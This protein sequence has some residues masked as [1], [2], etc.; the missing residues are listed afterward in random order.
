MKLTVVVEHILLEILLI[1][2]H[3]MM[4][5]ISQSRCQSTSEVCEEPSV[6]VVRSSS[7]ALVPY[8]ENK[9]AVPDFYLAERRLQFGEFT[10]TVTQ[11][12]QEVGVAAVVWDAV[13]SWFHFR[14][15]LC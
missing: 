12:W 2:S 14:L 15:G 3:V 4:D 6:G 10:V 13:S 5:D 1:F 8:D 11:N 7:W 9:L